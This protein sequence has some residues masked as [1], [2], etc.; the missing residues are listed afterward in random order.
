MP[1]ATNRAPRAALFALFFASGAAALVY[2]V[3][4]LK[5]LGLV[6]GNTA[7]A[8]STALA[9]FFLGMAA[10]GRVFGRRA[11]GYARPLR[12]YA[13]LE[14]AVAGSALLFL[15]LEPAFRTVWVAAY[16]WLEGN[17]AAATAV[18][19]VLAAGLLFLPAFFMGG[20]LPVMGQ[21]LVRSAGELGRVGT[22]LY[23][24]NT[25]GA[26]AGALTAG[27][28]LPETLGLRASVLAAAALNVAVGIVA[29]AMDRG[30]SRARVAVDDLD[31]DGPADAAADTHADADAPPGPGAIRALAFLSGFLVLGLEV[32]WTRMFAQVLQNSVYSFTVILV[33]FLAALALGSGAASLLVRRTWAPA[34]VI[35]ALAVAAWLLI[36]ASTALF[37]SATNGLDDVAPGGGW[38]AYV[39]RVAGLAA[40][41]MLLPGVVAGTLYP[42]LIKV[43]ERLHLGAGRTLGDL[44]AVNAVGGILGSLAAGFAVL[45]AF[46]LWQ[47][48]HAFAA[49][50]L[51]A[52]GLA[53]ARTTASRAVLAAAAAAVAGFALVRVAVPP[54]PL[55]HVDAAQGERLVAAWE[56]R[57]GV[58]AVV[59]RGDNRTIKVD[60]HYTL[61]DRA[62]FDS[63][64]RQ[65]QLPLLV[66]PVPRNV[67][68]LGMGTGITAAAALDFPVT[69]VVTCELVPEVVTAAR[70]H[71]A[72]EAGPL[73][74]DGRSVIVVEDG[75]QHLLGTRERFDLIVSDLF[76]P[77]HAGTGSLYTREHFALCRSRLAPGGTFVLWVPAFQ[78]TREGFDVLART[79]LEVFPHVTV[80]RGEF[81]PRFPT[82]GFVCDTDDVRLDPGIAR[83]N[84]AHVLPPGAPP[85]A[86]E[87]RY[88]PWMHYAGNLATARALFAHARVDT[89]DHPVLEYLA[90]KAQQR[91]ESRETAWL[92]GDEMVRLSEELLAAA[93]P[94]SDPYLAAASPAQVQ[95]VRAGHR[96]LA[97]SAHVDAGRTADAA[98]EYREFLA[99]VPFDVFPGLAGR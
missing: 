2:E 55:V 1:P 65:A 74:R 84:L 92:R 38:S 21:H 83:R 69:R 89:D 16:P 61:G 81:A 60:N 46:G 9:V 22:L 66:R 72:R 87:G 86:A 90:P 12:A 37:A 56:G 97:V 67:F 70:E 77:W 78:L 62:A 18:K 73:F 8:A 6:F 95:Y 4:W 47:G 63:E 40:A 93:P 98:R 85:D 5:E 29:W 51:L 79:V 64:R 52:A 42:Y 35:P 25:V 41:V 26:A 33:T 88:L 31:A 23:L 10:G 59:G 30:D 71:F 99:V 91:A 39:G 57:H 3:L 20:T 43:A 53:V 94:E 49:A 45:P 50:Y 15:L 75:R 11:A 7:Y 24:V 19:V 96:L 28:V 32:L 54:L 36:A 76:V 14:W 34:R 68:F 44:A 48:L 82:L 58:V 13:W 17:L 27:F 80:W